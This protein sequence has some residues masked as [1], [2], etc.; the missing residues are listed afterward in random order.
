MFILPVVISFT[1]TGIRDPI[2]TEFPPA[3]DVKYP[4]LNES[5]CSE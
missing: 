3:S 2:V 1:L 5:F 4:K